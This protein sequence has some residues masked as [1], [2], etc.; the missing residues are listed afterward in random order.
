[1]MRLLCLYLLV[2]FASSCAGFKYPEVRS[3]HGLKMVR[4]AGRDLSLE[5][6]AVIYNPNWFSIKVKPSTVSITA[7]NHSLGTLHLEKKI[8]L[9]GRATD[10]LAIPVKFHLDDGAMLTILRLIIRDS[11][12]LQIKGKIKGGVG[13]LSKKQ[14]ID[15]EQR[16]PGRLLRWN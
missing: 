16:I 4:M 12:T 15:L 13:I 3:T 9:K 5:A 2:I 1:M 6:K 14:K 8:K 7:D 11:V 10:T